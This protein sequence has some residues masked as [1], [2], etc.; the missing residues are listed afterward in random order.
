MHP[1][2]LE[3]RCAETPTIKCTFTHTG[4]FILGRDGV[5][6]PERD[7]D[8][9]SVLQVILEDAQLRVA[10]GRDTGLL[11]N[12]KPAAGPTPV[13]H[14][15]WVTLGD[16][17]Y[18][19]RLIWQ[20]DA[21]TVPVPAPAVGSGA[22]A[23]APAPQPATL[24]TPAT[25]PRV[26]LTG[27]AQVLIGRHHDCTLAIDSPLVSRHHARL[28]VNDGQWQIEDLGS[29]N[30]SFVNGRR[31]REPVAL[32]VGDRIG[33]ATFLYRF[34]G[35]GLR[36]DGQEGRVRI[37][38]LGVTRTVKDRASG[39]SRKLLDDIS[40]VIEPGEFVVIFGGSGSGKSTLLDT[41][42]GR[43]PATG[44]RVL[45]NGV[46]FYAAFDMYRSTI[47]YVPQQDI[48][49]R[50][51]GMRRALEY[52]ARL[53]LPAD[54]AEHE[55][56][57]YLDEV[58][59]SVRLQEQAGLLIDT[60]S[61]LS[62]GQ[63]KRVSLAA[64]L[65]AKP[66]VLFLDEVT[67]GLDAG[68]DRQMMQTF[69]E[70]ADGGK[71]VICVTHTLE[72]IAAC[73]LVTLLHR[74]RLAYF[75]PPAEA[76]DYFKL[77]RLSDI[78][79]VLDTRPPEHWAEQYQASP[80]RQRHVEARLSAAALAPPATAP[81]PLV[82]NTA[83]RS[84]LW[85]QTRILTRRYVDLM[86]GDKRNLA[87]LVLQAPLI[88]GVVGTVFDTSGPP[89]TQ[90]VAQGQV[91]FM[92]VLSAIWF[93]CLNSAREIVKELPVYL[94]ERSVN[95]GLAPYILSKLLPLATL[96]LI[97]CVLLLG[98]VSATLTL[99]GDF[100]PRLLLL[101]ASAFAASAMGLAISAFVDTNDKAIAMVPILLIPQVVLSNALT[102]LDGL[103]LWVAKL[104]M[105]SFWGYDAMKA[106]L[107]PEVLAARD[108]TG[109][110]VLPVLESYGLGVGVTLV[111]TLA[112]LGLVGIGLRLKD[113][114]T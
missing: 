49:H 32:K 104:S 65:I 56:A 98:V 23:P 22:P 40:L 25:V 45:Y 10:P 78:Y 1:V 111:M 21:P 113:R 43:R 14:G 34:T 91:A 39:Q 67:S 33:I 53:R 12:G 82:V 76:Q 81:A 55:I 112:F 64:E 8:R 41:L 69:A 74:G 87:I 102:R 38:A 57:A 2:T 26:T 99:P 88:G 60:P 29:I 73:Q 16:I 58:L 48:V 62:G 72:N 79:D 59:A 44:G 63:L 42:N 110:A 9:R 17:V 6:E 28:T 20:T 106:T 31:I 35:D 92:L 5:F 66:G 84:S 77:K 97:Q 47:G 89:A 107:S 54:T 85:R 101:T 103:N 52:T 61:P 83:A 15:D 36:A 7:A 13:Q 114:S 18:Q 93:G 109:A 11:V 96:C 70:L 86:L 50:R 3:L 37:E 27:G 46:D 4:T 108:P 105:L 71:T 51:I 100:L 94:R 80:E 68:T 95:L 30:G 90:A 75:G 19:L 24:A